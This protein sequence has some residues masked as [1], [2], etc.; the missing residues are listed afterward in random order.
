MARLTEY[1]LAIAEADTPEAKAAAA[2]AAEEFIANERRKAIS[3]AIGQTKDKARE[4]LSSQ[5]DKLRRR[6]NLGD[7]FKQDFKLEYIPIL[8]ATTFAKQ[9]SGFVQGIG[10]DFNSQVQKVFNNIK[11]TLPVLNAQINAQTGELQETVFGFRGFSYDATEATKGLGDR[12]QQ[13]LKEFLTPGETMK[14]L[15]QVRGAFLENFP[16]IRLAT[17]QGEE[18]LTRFTVAMAAAN[19]MPPNK[20][21][22]FFESLKFSARATVPEMLAISKRVN[23][24]TAQLGIPMEQG[25]D[26]FQYVTDQLGYSGQKA[27]RVFEGLQ[28]ASLA[29]GIPVRELGESFDRNLQTFDGIANL[30]GRLNAVLGISI[31]PMALARMEPDEKFKYIQ[32]MIQQS[33]MDITDPLIQRELEGVLGGRSSARRIL[34]SSREDFDKI[35]AR[36]DRARVPKFDSIDEANKGAT[37]EIERLARARRGT[38]PGLLSQ[39][40]QQN[41]RFTQMI[42]ALNGTSGNLVSAVETYSGT[43]LK[44]FDTGTKAL[45]ILLERTTGENADIVRKVLTSFATAAVL[46]GDDKFGKILTAL[47]GTTNALPAL[48]K[49]L[50]ELGVDLK[51]E[52]GQ[53][54]SGEIIPTTAL[55]KTAAAVVK[56]TNE[57][58]EKMLRERKDVD[59]SNAEAMAEAFSVKFS[60]ETNKNYTELKT[61]IKDIGKNASNVFRLTADSRFPLM[62]LIDK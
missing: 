13:P 8:D 45:R 49:K 38:V 55:I 14:A 42:K 36:T 57:K 47:I 35:D 26:N 12:I 58:Y 61:A 22:S 29:T 20:M 16:G 43:T 62:R 37:E 24:F 10:S 52:K 39:I 33:G 51:F 25:V 28:K 19:N 3:E 53:I 17:T 54:K 23:D 44:A 5:R 30:S 59:A 6:F 32:D 9:F 4:N 2:A 56:E 18:A 31:D 21:A 7:S 11:T 15:N 27:M 50:K 60:A 46:T 41:I 40:D 1:L 48:Q 34:R